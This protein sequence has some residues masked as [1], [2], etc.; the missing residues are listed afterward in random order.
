MMKKSNEIVIC[1]PYYGRRYQRLFQQGSAQRLDNHLTPQ[2]SEA[3]YLSCPSR[4]GCCLEK[5]NIRPR[6]HCCENKQ[7]KEACSCAKIEEIKV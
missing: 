4:T 1:I 5:A 3:S 6:E 7:T 2:C